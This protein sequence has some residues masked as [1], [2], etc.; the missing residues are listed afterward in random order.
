L[1][2]SIF[3]IGHIH[4]LH[5][6]V[7]GGKTLTPRQ[8]GAISLGGLC[9]GAVIV[10]FAFTLLDVPLWE[11]MIYYGIGGYFVLTFPWA[12]LDRES[13]RHV[14]RAH[15]RLVYLFIALLIVILIVQWGTDGK[16]FPKWA[17]GALIVAAVA[18]YSVMGYHAF[19]NF[20]R[21]RRGDF[22]EPNR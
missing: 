11:A 22:T 6:S 21:W 19:L 18:F 8:A 4:I 14:V 16:P 17:A 13:I 1:E 15:N 7:G 5:E 10:V 12:C 9:V 2:L 3:V 20:K